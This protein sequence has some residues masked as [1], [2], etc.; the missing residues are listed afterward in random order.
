MA[1]KLPSVKQPNP[2]IDKSRQKAVS[3]SFTNDA[4]ERYALFNE[5]QTGPESK[6]DGLVRQN[7]FSMNQ[8]R[9]ERAFQRY[10]NSQVTP[11]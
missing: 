3:H 11:E 5:K 9:K 7:L 8:S 1:P 10:G 6:E 4:A 2:S